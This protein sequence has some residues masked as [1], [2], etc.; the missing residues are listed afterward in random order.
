MLVIM[1]V[2]WK[3]ERERSVQLAPY[4]FYSFDL[5]FLHLILT[6]NSKKYGTNFIVRRQKRFQ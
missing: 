1:V 4:L 5:I 2:A 3:S 6:D